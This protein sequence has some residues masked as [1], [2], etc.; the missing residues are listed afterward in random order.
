MAMRWLMDRVSSSYGHEQVT[1]PDNIAGPFHRFR[2]LPTEL[3]LQIWEYYFDVPRIHVLYQGS[4]KSQQGVEETPVAYADLTARTNHNVPASR[5]FAAAAI[6]HEA[7]E[8]FL[9]TFDFVHMDFMSMP[10]KHVKTLFDERLR[11]LVDP[12]G[13]DPAQPLRISR[14]ILRSRPDL[15][16]LVRNPGGKPRDR[17]LSGAHIN[18]ENDLLYLTDSGDVNC[19]ML[20]RA[21]NGPIA[22]KLRRVAMLIHDGCKYEGFRRFYGPSVDFPKPSANLDEIVLVVRLSN[23]DPSKHATIDRDDFGFVPY[24]S[25]MQGEKGGSWEWMQNMKLIERRFVY[26]AQ[27][28]R[29][30]FPG[31]EDH[32]I[33]WAV[34]I[35]YIHRKAETQYSRNLRW[36]GRLGPGALL[37]P[38]LASE[39]ATVAH[40]SY[41][42]CYY[43]KAASDSFDD[44]LSVSVAVPVVGVVAAAAAALHR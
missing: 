32:K 11:G 19:E 43:G 31:L 2:D 22:S 37:T 27:V 28:L 6:N 38:V 5:R 25:I 33:K 1:E 15:A 14:D 42:Y 9:K 34:D 24:D 36:T 40:N 12:E 20:R 10:S 16:E 3:R 39:A 26:V 13:Q 7:F 17:V 41:Y 23:F 35:D 30:A 21:C 18:W 4:P 29:E 8:V 44:G